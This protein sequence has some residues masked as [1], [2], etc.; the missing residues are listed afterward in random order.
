[1]TPDGQKTLAAMLYHQKRF[2][3]SAAFSILSLEESAKSAILFAMLTVEEGELPD[4]WREYRNH[5]AKTGTMGMRMGSRIRAVMPDISPEK[6]HKIGADGPSPDEFESMK[7]GAIYSDCYVWDGDVVCLQ[8]GLG[9]WRQVAWERLCEAQALAF[10]Q[11]DISPTELKSRARVV[12]AAKES[13]RDMA[14]AIR[15]LYSELKDKGFVKEGGWDT[16][17]SDLDSGLIKPET[18]ES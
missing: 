6:A 1:V 9:D 4:P 11:R 13:G 12:K 17:I 10:G 15:E 7:Q 2:P 3:H 14:S 18:K 8:P 5:R 16:L